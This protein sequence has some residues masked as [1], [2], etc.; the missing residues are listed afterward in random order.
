M[1]TKTTT[2]MNE[3]QPSPVT[4]ANVVPNRG[5]I[6]VDVST[7]GDSNQLVSGYNTTNLSVSSLQETT[8][9]TA[10]FAQQVCYVS[11]IMVLYQMNPDNG[12]ISCSF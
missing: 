11:K 4:N 3:R 8:A 5:A 10:T 7:F 9:S 12:R 2:S 1:M 6:G